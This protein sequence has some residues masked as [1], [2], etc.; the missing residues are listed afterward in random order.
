[1]L[2]GNDSI[3]ERLDAGG[4]TFREFNYALMQARDFLHLYRTEGCSLQVGGSDQWGNITAGTE[5]I[6]RT[7]GTQ[8]YGLTL[9]LVVT[10]QGH[11]M[12]KTAEGAIW[13]DADMTTPFA[14]YQFWYRTDDRDLR[15]FAAWYTDLDPVEFDHLCHDDVRA[16]KAKL[17]FAVTALVHGHDQ[18]ELAAAAG[19]AAFY[20]GRADGAQLPTCVLSEGD[21]TPSL[22]DVLLT[23]GLAASRSS[24]RRLIEAGGVYI[25]ERRE[26][27]PTARLSILQPIILRA[28]RKRLARIVAAQ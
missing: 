14:F 6:R 16:A 27:D 10:A 7:C 4:L 5:L 24:A 22:I 13:L 21:E 19:R 9:P 12:G 28:G 3:R 18:A 15:Q 11:K 2:L 26:Q 25:D 8:A 23:S 17:A 20:G 1:M